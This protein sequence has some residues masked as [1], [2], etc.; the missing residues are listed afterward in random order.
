MIVADLRGYRGAKIVVLILFRFLVRLSILMGPGARNS[1]VHR[2]SA[3]IGYNIFFAPLG[4]FNT[5]IE[6][7]DFDNRQQYLIEI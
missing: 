2:Y 4:A 5:G 7:E 6:P 3:P 1:N